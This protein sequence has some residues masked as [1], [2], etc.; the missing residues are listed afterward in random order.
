MRAT[1]VRPICT[2]RKVPVKKAL[3]LGWM[4]SART[5]MAR[6]RKRRATKGQPRP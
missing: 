2:T 5:C 3:L 1:E 6:G 4:A